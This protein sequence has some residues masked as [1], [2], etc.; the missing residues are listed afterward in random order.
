MKALAPICTNC[1]K[2]QTV[3]NARERGFRDH[4]RIRPPAIACA[5]D[6]IEACLSPVGF[7][8]LTYLTEYYEEGAQIDDEAELQSQ[9][10]TQTGTI[11]TVPRLLSHLWLA[12]Q[13]LPPAPFISRC[14]SAASICLAIGS[15][16]WLQGATT[17]HSGRVEMAADLIDDGSRSYNYAVRGL[18]VRGNGSTRNFYLTRTLRSSTL[19]VP[20]TTKTALHL[21]N[22]CQN[23]FLGPPPHCCHGRLGQPGPRPW[24]Y[25]CQ[26]GHRCSPN[27]GHQH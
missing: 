3:N 15:V 25:R 1:P 12:T 26:A 27:F 14:A 23:A 7:S 24:P 13:C 6:A 5:T 16:A 18:E 20:S 22:Y 21:E 4:G 8:F 17:P 10:R 19:T 2:P 11:T 9:K